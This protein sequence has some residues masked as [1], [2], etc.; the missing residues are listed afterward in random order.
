[1][2]ARARRIVNYGR[3]TSVA[4]SQR[5]VGT[6]HAFEHRESTNG[7]RG[8]AGSETWSVRYRF[9]VKSAWAIA[10]HHLKPAAPK[11]PRSSDMR[12]NVGAVTRCSR[13]ARR[14]AS[15]PA[16]GI[17]AASMARR[18]Q[19]PLS[20]PANVFI[21]PPGCRRGRVGRG[22]DRRRDR[23]DAGGSFRSAK[24]AR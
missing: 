16:A 13:Q 1:M 15:A 22:S 12:R 23:R 2:A 5:K 8:S 9:S 20:K 11:A 10:K 14:P 4:H 21:H 7:V 6:P 24:Q 17:V 19:N 3:T 18:C